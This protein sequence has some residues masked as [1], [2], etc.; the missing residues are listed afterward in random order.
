MFQAPDQQESVTH[1]P[2]L[3]GSP[4]QWVSDM[5]YL[6]QRRADELHDT[7]IE[8]KEINKLRLEN[9]RLKDE[10]EIIQMHPLYDDASDRINVSHALWL[11]QQKDLERLEIYKG[12]YFFALFSSVWLL[13]ILLT[14]IVFQFFK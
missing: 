8:R 1:F 4:Q 13:M 11:R 2:A 6:R 7:E 9:R 10:L 14:V 3:L 5:A 12:R